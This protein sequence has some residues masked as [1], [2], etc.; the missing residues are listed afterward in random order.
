MKLTGKLALVTGASSGI[1]EATA[2]LLAS[3]GATVLLVARREHE[4]ARIAAAIEADGGRAKGFAADLSDPAAVATAAS[5]V[6]AEF[7][8]PDAI[9][10][11]AGAGRWLPLA[12]TDP[13]EARRMIELPYLAALY[14]TRQFVPAMLERGSGSITNVTSVASFL[15]WPNACAYI[16]A[17][18]ALKG[19]NDALRAETR[20][21]GLRV[22]L[23]VMGTVESPYWRNNPGS[24]DNVPASIPGLMPVLTT[25]DAA[26]LVVA[27]M[28]RDKIQVVRPRIFRLL[29]ALNCLFPSL[30]SRSMGA[31]KRAG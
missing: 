31:E 14:V 8:V 11:C 20:D 23:V 29:F 12:A 19:F 15:A 22:T 17:R 26:D 6:R 25:Q 4:L 21:K 24:R 9:V 1:G 2:K 16:A 3:R 30:V 7:G 27:A 28:E 13:D 5:A 18:H 10:N